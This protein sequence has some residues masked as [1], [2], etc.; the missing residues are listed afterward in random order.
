[1]KLTSLMTFHSIPRRLWL[2]TPSHLRRQFCRSRDA[3]CRLHYIEISPRVCSWHLHWPRRTQFGELKNDVRSL[4]AW[5]KAKRAHYFETGEWP[6]VACGVLVPKFWATLVSSLRTVRRIQLL[7]C[8]A[9]YRT[10]EPPIGTID[11]QVVCWRSVMVEDANTNN[12]G[13]QLVPKDIAP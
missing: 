7:R 1:M 4:C 3:K 8:W 5:R 2:E 10:L 6:A 11:E 12:N 13:Q 9:S